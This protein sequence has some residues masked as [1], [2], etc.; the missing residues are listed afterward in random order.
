MG[1]GGIYR[2]RRPIRHSFLRDARWP[3]VKSILLRQFAGRKAVQHAVLG[4]S[5][6]LATLTLAGGAGAQP[7]EL[8][9]P[10]PATLSADPAQTERI[11]QV[12]QRPTTQSLTLVQID[13]DALRG[14]NVQMTL[15]G[16]G[17]LTMSGRTMEQRDARDFTWVGGLPGVPGQATLV[18]HNGDVTGTINDGANLY[19]VEPVGRGVHALIKV[20]QSRFPPE[21][22]PSF[23]ERERR[24]GVRPLAPRDIQRSDTPIGIDVLV[25]YTPSAAGAVSN[26]ATT[27][28][29][30]VA[31]A[32]VSYQ[33]SGINI[34][35]N[36]VDSF[37]VAY[38][39]G[40]NT[41]DKILADFAGN[42]NV[43]T[44]RD[45]SAADV[46]VLIIN[47]SDYCGL[48]DAIMANANNAFAVVYYDCATGYY[49]FAHE[50]GHLQG[51]RHDPAN[52]PSTTPFAYGHG[53]QHTTPP[54][55]WRTIMAYNCAG[56][57][58]RLQYWSNP[59][60]LYN[61]IPMGT[62]ATNNNARVLNETA[63][64]VAAFRSKPITGKTPL[65]FGTLLA[66]GQKSSGTNNWT[67]TYNATYKRY[68]ITIQGENYYYLNY[69][70]N[71]TPTGDVRFCRT[72]SVSGKLLVYCYD[73]AGA[74]APSRFAFGAYKP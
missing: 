29:L 62:A 71:V 32:N 52:D 20:D 59:N 24:G 57:C 46:A 7:R 23:Q 49:S 65:A 25:A 18:I 44:R 58:P 43:N 69:A 37:Q 51:A 10:V 68:E 21:H 48:A 63:A 16:A 30:A 38:T 60:V 8:F 14:N 22:P 15:P 39:E 4:V 41:F 36:L 11:D 31:E 17:T 45:S 6:V 74:V 42:S 27:I 19:R 70:T 1:A 61:G 3:K 34:H 72:D 5:L 53:F 13:V 55:P 54:P 28:Q 64:T 47:K 50:I 35:L 12:R 2:H 73:P 26:I 9:T 33:N 56:G 40:S 67:S 66:N